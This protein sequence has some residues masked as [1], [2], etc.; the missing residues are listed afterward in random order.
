MPQAPEGNSTPGL[1]MSEAHAPRPLQHASTPAG[2]LAPQQPWQ[3]GYSNPGCTSSLPQRQLQRQLHPDAT[4]QHQSLLLHQ[5]RPQHQAHTHPQPPR[6]SCETPPHLL[7]PASLTTP[8]SPQ[9]WHRPGMQARA[10]SPRQ[11]VPCTAE[12]SIAEAS[13]AAPPAAQSS[14]PADEE[15]RPRAT[16][17]AL[18]P[19]VQRHRQSPAPPQ[20][21][22]PTQLQPQHGAGLPQPASPLQ[23]WR[24]NPEPLQPVSPALSRGW[25]GRSE[26]AKSEQV[27]CSAWKIQATQNTQFQA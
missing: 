26:A 13:F 14:G 6:L 25:D 17:P 22:R 2:Q 23:P 4:L 24:Q 9:Q 5:Q 8:Q 3:P 16:P 27:P 12:S 7:S 1:S 15:P 11:R 18:R 21:Q 20:H 10:P 19:Q